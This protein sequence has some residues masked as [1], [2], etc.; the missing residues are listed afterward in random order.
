MT[1]TKIAIPVAL[2]LLSACVNPV[3]ETKPVQLSSRDVSRIKSAVRYE[4]IDANSAEFRNIQAIDIVRQ[5]GSVTRTVCGEVNAKN[6]SGGYVGYEVFSAEISHQGIKLRGIDSPT[7]S[8]EF[9]DSFYC[10]PF[11]GDS[12]RRKTW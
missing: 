4:L 2:L 7:D 11:L 5:D 8:V 3:S 10:A 1:K 6:R 9:I 12:W